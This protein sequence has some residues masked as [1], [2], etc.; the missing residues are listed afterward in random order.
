MPNAREVFVGELAAEPLP[1]DDICGE[2]RTSV[3]NGRVEDPAC[4]ARV[5]TVELRLD[6]RAESA[7]CGQTVGGRGGATE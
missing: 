6:E 5:V 7:R 3:R 4:E 2:S 1:D